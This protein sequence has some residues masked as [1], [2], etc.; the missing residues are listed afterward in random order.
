[1]AK[2]K[3]KI[4][5]SPKGIHGWL[6]LVVIIFT[7]SALNATYLLI[8]RINWMFTAPIGAGVYISAFILLIYTSLMWYSI[9]LIAE[10]KKKAKKFS[11]A[12]LI[13]GFIFTLWY[14]L[15]GLIFFLPNFNRF[16]VI[17]SIFPILLNLIII[18]A[19]ISYLKK[20][21]RVKNTLIR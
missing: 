3:N 18:L 15:I 16:V 8:Q 12:A 5:K 13:T 11:I 7:I 10:H 17:N 6:A 2:R 9:F 14:Y 4:R 1:M 21:K 20:S 19:I